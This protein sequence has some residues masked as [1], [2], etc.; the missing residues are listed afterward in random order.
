[1]LDVF[2]RP[3]CETPGHDSGVSLCTGV[4]DRFNDLQAVVSRP[5]DLQLREC[6]TVRERRVRTATVNQGA[7]PSAG[8]L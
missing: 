6:G 2:Y 5:F 4:S 3:Q 8:K 1:M 7:A